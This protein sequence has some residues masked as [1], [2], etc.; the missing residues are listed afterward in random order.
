MSDRDFEEELKTEV[1]L[2]IKD[3]LAKMWP[4]SRDQAE[5]VT[6]ILTMRMLNSF[7]IGNAHGATV[8]G[9]RLMAMV[10]TLA[11]KIVKMLGEHSEQRSSTDPSLSVG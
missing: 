8:T 7:K 3:V 5:E 1:A 9:Q 2:L 4:I 11:E 6:K 10:P